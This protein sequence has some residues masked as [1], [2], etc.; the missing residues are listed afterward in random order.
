MAASKHLGW[1]SLL[2]GGAC[3]KVLLISQAGWLEFHL[4]IYRMLPVLLPN[5]N[6]FRRLI[7]SNISKS[8]HTNLF[9]AHRYKILTFSDSPNGN[10]VQLNADPVKQASNG[11]QHVGVLRQ[12][13]AD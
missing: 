3:Q 1:F 4:L 6:Q 13:G 9:T 2:H 12:K 10:I 7:N 5:I 8:L 11:W